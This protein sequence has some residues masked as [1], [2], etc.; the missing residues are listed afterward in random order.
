M[1][2]R[3]KKRS[4]VESRL[5]D[6]T[7]P[8]FVLDHERR[9]CVFNLGCEL[10][11]GWPAVDVV[12]TLCNYASEVRE[13][14]VKA[15]ASSLCPPPEVFGGHETQA[16]AFIAHKDGQLV[17]RLLH[18]FPLRDGTGTVTGVLGVILPIRQ[19]IP[20]GANSPVRQLHAELAALRSMVR[21]RF[22]PESLVCRSAPMRKILSQV[23]LAQRSSAFVLLTGEAGTGKEH[24]A[25]GIHFGSPSKANWFVPLDCRRL[26]PDE[27]QRVLSRLLEVHQ[28]RPS[29][30]TGPQPG[31]VYLAEIEYLPRDL[32]ERLTLAFTNEE[33]EVG[34]GPNL[35]LLASSAGDLKQAVEEG[36]LRSDF[37]ELI[38]TLTI[39]IPPLRQRGDD[40]PLLSQYCLE[41]VNRLGKKQVGGFDE[42][43]WPFFVRYDW[44]GNLDE[45]S[46]VVREAHDSCRDTLIKLA[47]L[48][49]RF[50]TGLEA[51]ELPPAAESLPIPLDPLL[52]KVETELILQALKRCKYNKSR[53]ADLLGITRPRL[54][55]RMEQLGIEDREGTAG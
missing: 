22:G 12:G 25:R 49:F 13:A 5:A 9:V 36:T 16:P 7:S 37:F 21:A 19:P 43:V 53:A 42:S 50:R 40:L 39:E 26:G 35:R 24:V 29:D 1:K 51:Q 47:D 44:P 6:S 33:D 41:E 20:A 18:F 45:L 11:S 4:E 31:T 3:A 32:Q 30:G 2:K 14:G 52:V 23:E 55:R 38:S 10:L 27:L 17:P 48:P 28:P 34:S 54:Y 8:L 15:L 46:T